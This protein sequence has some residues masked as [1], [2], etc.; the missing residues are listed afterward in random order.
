[1]GITVKTTCYKDLAQALNGHCESHGH[2]PR[3]VI[4]DRSRADEE[5]LNLATLEDLKSGVMFNSKWKSSPIEI[6]VP[7]VVVFS[8]HAP[9]FH[10]PA[11]HL[12][13]GDLMLTPDRLVDSNG[14]TTIYNLRD[15]ADLFDIDDRTVTEPPEVPLFTDTTIVFDSSD[16][17]DADASTDHDADFI[18]D[19]EAT[20]PQSDVETNQCISRQ[21]THR[22][23]N[24][25]EA[26]AG[27][28]VCATCHR[29]ANL[30]LTADFS[31]S[32]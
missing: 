31:P 28:P 26:G 17:E 2:G 29:I 5:P 19:E 1:M 20:E 18:C 21:G 32:S 4:I 30:G 6:G 27:D 12:N 25:L 16:E 23:P 7:I 22:C 15:S 11:G 24:Y 13:S 10:Y 9:N 14:R 3:V 8:N